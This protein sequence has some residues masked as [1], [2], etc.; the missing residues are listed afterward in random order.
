MAFGMLT[1]PHQPFVFCE[2]ARRRKSHGTL[3]VV[4][5]ALWWP[6]GVPFAPS[7]LRRERV[8]LSLQRFKLREHELSTKSTA[9]FHLRLKPHIGKLSGLTQ[10]HTTKIANQR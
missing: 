5:P 9:P 2:D 10:R 8:Q 7:T 1:E 4:A 6:A 3:V